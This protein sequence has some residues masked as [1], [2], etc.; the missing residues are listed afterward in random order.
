MSVGES[1]AQITLY[2]PGVSLGFCQ[3]WAD[4]EEAIFSKSTQ[5]LVSAGSQC[6][7]TQIC[8]KGTFVL[9]T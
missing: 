4:P 9:L 3:R 2:L 7:E 6:Q 8:T 1:Q 5:V